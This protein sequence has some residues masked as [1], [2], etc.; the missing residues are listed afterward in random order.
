MVQHSKGNATLDTDRNG[1]L[2]MADDPYLSAWPRV[3]YEVPGEPRQ[4]LHET[5]NGD[6]LSGNESAVPRPPL[7]VGPD[8]VQAARSVR[9]GSPIQRVALN[10]GS[11]ERRH[12]EG[13]AQTSAEPGDDGDVRRARSAHGL[14]HRRSGFRRRVHE[15][16][17]H[18][19][20][21]EAVTI[22]T[23]WTSGPTIVHRCRTEELA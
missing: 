23:R 13:V 7:P 16:L 22:P 15:R 9:D 12:R 5:D 21:E 19:P 17:G 1:Q 11:V 20:D 4:S 14:L 3:E 6:S 18:G 10:T 8:E 2:T